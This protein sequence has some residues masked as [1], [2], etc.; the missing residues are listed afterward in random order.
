[1]K[2]VYNKYIPF[3]GYRVLNFFGI[4][5]VRDESG[6]KPTLSAQTLNH[7]EIHNAQMRELLYIPYYILYLCEYVYR[8]VAS[9][10][11]NGVKA[12]TSKVQKET[13][14]KVSFELE[15]ESGASD[16]NYISTRSKYAWTKYI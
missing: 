14:H 7:E 3:K 2:I 1:M 5:F 8:R 4:L 11:A 12:F 6:K 9:V 13:Y 15:A 10:L 16:P